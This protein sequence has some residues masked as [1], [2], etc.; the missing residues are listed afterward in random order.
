MCGVRGTV[1]NENENEKKRRE[2]KEW[3]LKLKQRLRLSMEGSKHGVTKESWRWGIASLRNIDRLDSGSNAHVV[4]NS[5][6][7]QIYKRIAQCLQHIHLWSSHCRVPVELFRSELWLQNTSASS[8]DYNLGFEKIPVVAEGPAET[9]TDRWKGSTVLKELPT[10][11]K[12]THL[13]QAL[14]F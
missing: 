4:Q 8:R 13:L 6:W 12:R 11:S 1:T 9:K 7:L 3:D 2:W 5:F 10:E 14:R